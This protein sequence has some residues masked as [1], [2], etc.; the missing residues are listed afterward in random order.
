MPYEKARAQMDRSPSRPS[1]FRVSIPRQVQNADFAA[2]DYLKFFCKT[3][4]I[5]SISHETISANGHERMGVIRQQPVGVNYQKPFTITVIERTDFIVYSQM[6]EWFDR[7]SPNSNNPN[8]ALSQRMGYYNSYICDIKLKKLEY[9]ITS[10]YN[11]SVEDVVKGKT[12][13]DGFESPL[14]VTFRN[15]Y[16]TNIGD[17]TLSSDARDQLLEYQISFNYETFKTETKDTDND[18]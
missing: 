9:A 6:K 18:D 8:I 15:A 16:V 2:N 1:L 13:P 14:I 11:E 7:T 12:T 17:I 10:N 3:A 4:N 5:P